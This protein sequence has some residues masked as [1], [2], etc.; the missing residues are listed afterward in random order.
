M[1]D[2][3]AIESEEEQAIYR[4]LEL[5]KENAELE[6]MY[7]EEECES[8]KL[9]I[10]TVKSNHSLGASDINTFEETEE[11]GSEIEE[12]KAYEEEARRAKEDQD[13]RNILKMPLRS[14]RLTNFEK[15]KGL[16]EEKMTEMNEINTIHMMI[17]HWH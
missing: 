10:P 1:I 13:F 11:E 9:A 14:R 17:D 4:M 15:N 16:S 12:L 8:P 3:K 5:I 7:E 6:K 2:Q